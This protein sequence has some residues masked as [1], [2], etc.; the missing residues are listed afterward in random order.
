MKIHC[1]MKHFKALENKVEIE[2]K[3]MQEYDNNFF[4]ACDLIEALKKGC[5]V[6]FFYKEK[7]YS[8]THLRN[9]KIIIGE[10]YNSDSEKIYNEESQVLEYKI[11][12]KRL[13]D[14]ITEMKVIERSF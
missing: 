8:I 6:E 10:F 5:E 1:G 14:I 4:D 2:M 3:Y 12:D 11:E 9:G 7:K 13:K